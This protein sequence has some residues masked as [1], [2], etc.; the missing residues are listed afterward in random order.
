[1][2]VLEWKWEEIAM[3]FAVELPRTQFGYDSLWEIVDRLA[4]VA[5]FI[6]IK[7]TYTRPQLAELYSSRIVC[8]HGVPMRSVSDRETQVILTFW[9]R[10]HETLDTHLNFSSAYHPQSNGQ[11][12]RVN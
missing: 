6:S 8:F 3:D 12:K 4:K 5:H 9:E 1:L 11:T 7:M 2:Q 10:M